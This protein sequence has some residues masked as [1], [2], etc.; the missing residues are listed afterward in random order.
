M[1]T[2]PWKN[3]DDLVQ[4]RGTPRTSQNPLQACYHF[5]TAG[6][7][8]GCSEKFISVTMSTRRI[9]FLLNIFST[10]DGRAFPNVP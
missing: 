2:E 9:K 10:G 4:T 1:S 8:S 5:I 3:L 7:L 6:P